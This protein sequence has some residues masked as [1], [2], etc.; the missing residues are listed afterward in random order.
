MAGMTAER[1]FLNKVDSQRYKKL[2]PCQREFYTSKARFPAFVAGWGTGKTMCMI[3][4]AIF[5]CQKYPNNL[6]LI[7]RKTETSL[8]DST[9]QD[10]ERYTTLKVPNHGNVIIPGTNSMIMFR[11]ADNI[12]Q[13][14]GMLQ[15]INL[16]FFGIEQAEEMASADVFD[17]LRGRTRREKTSHQGI[18][19]ANQNGHNWIWRR[20][21][22]E[23]H[24]RPNYHLIEAN[25]FVN[26]RNL[27]DDTLADWEDLK[28]DAPKKYNRYVMNS[29]EDYDIEG[30]YYASLMSDNLKA[31]R[32]G[33][34]ILFDKDVPVYTFWDL[35]IRASD[36]TAIW[37]VQFI[38]EE[39][40]LIDY[41]ED[42][43]KGMNHYSKK[44]SEKPYEYAAH[45]LPPDV[46]QRLQGAEIVTRLDI[47]RKLRREPVR[48]VERHR[49]EERIACVRSI[50]NKCKFS[51][52]CERGVD[53]LNNYK[54][55]KYELQSTEEKPIFQ[56]KPADDEWTNGADSFGYMA[57]IKKYAPPR[58][59]EAY[60]YFSN[61]T[62][63]CEDDESE[64]GVT[65]LLGLS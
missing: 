8:R 22:K 21:K 40:H 24:L 48:V 45:Y 47:M 13:F 60:N 43:G 44:L 27:P 42:F 17:M 64:M 63:W 14:K 18:I 33:M 6:G 9:I 57:V 56:A 41:L 49:V 62:E 55:K 51:E 25:S 38:G 39:I 3:L 61:E 52:K 28:L 46:V 16:G 23:A 1:R 4:K 7:C 54:K 31:G 65:N 10:F 59:D 20:W 30:S 2:I 34:E 58:Q 35:G 15:N 11:H 12:G 50:L 26:R 5:L 37:F 19:I 32:V 29:W 36:T 53:C